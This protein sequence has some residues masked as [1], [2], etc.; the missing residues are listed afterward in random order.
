M[1]WPYNP[2]TQERDRRFTNLGYVL[3]PFQ[4]AKRK[5][6]SKEGGERETEKEGKKQ[7]RNMAG[8]QAIGDLHHPLLSKIPVTGY[9]LTRRN[10]FQYFM[11]N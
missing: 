8:L 6:R 1:V 7:G 2:R 11:K 5:M 9:V 10:L 3:D 4:K